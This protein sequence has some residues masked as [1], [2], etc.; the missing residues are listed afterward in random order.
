M[1]DFD[2]LMWE[3]HDERSKKMV[4]LVKRAVSEGRHVDILVTSKPGEVLGWELWEHLGF[5]Q[6]TSELTHV[7]WDLSENA[8]KGHLR[9]QYSNII[10]PS[11]L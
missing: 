7:L 10:P 8:E 4:E 3:I 6:G 5:S 9:I 1:T 2:K 11:R